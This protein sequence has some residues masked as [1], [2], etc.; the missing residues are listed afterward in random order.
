[1]SWNGF[2]RTI[3]S[4]LITKLGDKHSNQQEQLS[5]S[6]QENDDRP[7]IWMRIPY[8]GKQGETLLENA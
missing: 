2:S 4:L 6:D 7:K 3:R 1:M 5:L 8:F